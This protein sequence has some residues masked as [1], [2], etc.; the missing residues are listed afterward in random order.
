MELQVGLRLRAEVGVSS[1]VRLHGLDIGT[2]AVVAIWVS[3]FDYTAVIVSTGPCPL[4]IKEKFLLAIGI[5]VEVN[6]DLSHMVRL[7]LAPRLLITIASAAEVTVCLP[8]RRVP[9]LV[10]GGSAPT[11]STSHRNTSTSTHT[12]TSTLTST[13]TS[14]ST[15]LSWAHY[16]STISYGT[17]YVHTTTDGGAQGDK[18][19]TS[20]IV[21]TATY[22]VTSCHA[23]VIY[24]PAS[25]TQVFVTSTVISKTTVCPASSTPDSIP[26]E[27]YYAVP[28]ATDATTTITLTKCPAETRTLH[29]AP[30]TATPRP[31]VTVT[32]VLTV[33][34]RCEHEA[35]SYPASPLPYPTV[36]DYVYPTATGYPSWE[37]PAYP[38]EGQVAYP[39]EDEDEDPEQEEHDGPEEEEEE[40]EEHEYREGSQPAAYPA[41]QP[42]YLSK[43][44]FPA[45]TGA[46]VYPTGPNY[47]VV[48]AGAGHVGARL[49][50]AV[51]VVAALL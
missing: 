42:A 34:D 30:G 22:T 44:T 48:T 40:E 32:D 31:T 2:G 18:Y 24:C 17:G 51:G 7:S 27:W 38:E 5:A 35:T 4:S 28:D 50:V 47:P 19:V 10:S 29:L 49:A 36:T 45:A 21:T 26:T 12:S 41:G 43:S 13:S 46:P 39:E 16:N 25:Y 20:T 37:K 23:S 33:C 3:L 8:G 9:P 1:D 6:V 11:S 15:A 14:T